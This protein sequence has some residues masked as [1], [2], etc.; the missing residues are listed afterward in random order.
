MRCEV[1][2]IA[3]LGLTAAFD[4]GGGR[5]KRKKAKEKKEGPLPGVGSHKTERK[6]SLD[7]LRFVKAS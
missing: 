7:N 2:E 3:L 4:M 5:D 6:V 1:W